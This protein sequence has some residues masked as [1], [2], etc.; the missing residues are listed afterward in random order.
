MLNVSGYKKLMQKDKDEFAKYYLG[1]SSFNENDVIIQ[2]IMEPSFYT[3][4]DFEYFQ[5]E[6][7]LLSFI[8][9]P[10][11][12]VPIR[13]EKK[14]NEILPVYE[15]FEGELYK[16]F[17]YTQKYTLKDFFTIAIQF[18]EIIEYIHDQDLMFL[19]LN[20][21]NFIVNIEKGQ[22]SLLGTFN[23]LYRGKSIITDQTNKLLS[24]WEI[25]YI[26]P[27]LTGRINI[28]ADYRANLYTLGI[29]FYELLTKK[30]PFEDSELSETIH[31]HLARIPTSPSE[32]NADIPEILSNIILKLLEKSPDERYQSVN[33]VKKDFEYCY[34]EFVKTGWVKKF[35]L[36]YQNKAT[37]QMK[38]VLF[39]REKELESL[40]EGLACVFGG[41]SKTALISG[42]SGSGKTGL[43]HYLHNNN[44]EN[45][46]LFLEGKFDQLLRN[47]PYAP[48]IQAFKTWVRII[49]SKGEKNVTIWKSK[50]LHELGPYVS[51]LSFLLPEIEWIIGKQ[52]AIERMSSYDNHSH[53][54]MMFQ[55][56]INFISIEC[57]LIIFIDDLQW[58]DA[59]S[60]ELICYLINNT[61]ENRLFLIIAYR[62]GID[63]EENNQVNTALKESILTNL[64]DKVVISLQPLSIAQITHWISIQFDIDSRISTQISS[65]IY[66][67]TAG[68][69]FFITQIFR[70]LTKEMLVSADDEAMEHIQL[71][72]LNEISI[73]EDIVSFI[74]SRIKKLPEHDQK[75]L[76]AASCLGRKVNGELISE[77]LKIDSQNINHLLQDAVTKGF[78]VPI[79]DNHSEEDN[80][81][82]LF[83]HDRVQQALYSL[84][85]LD[86]KQ[87]L[88]L[89]IGKYL[90]E[91]QPIHVN[92]EDLFEAVSH[93]NI[94]TKLLS[95]EERKELATLNARAGREAIKV[96]AFQAAYN[97]YY[98]AKG[99]L[100]EN[101]WQDNYSLTFEI[102]KGLGE[103]AYLNSNFKLAENTFKEVI[104]KAKTKEEKIK[105]YNNMIMLFTHLHRVNE[106]VDAGLKGLQLFNWNIKP[107]PR[108]ADIAKEL[109]LIQFALINKKPATL[110]NL[111]HMKE[112]SQKLFIETLINL[113]APSFHVN[114]NLSTYLMLKAF[115]FTL[116]NGQTDF[117]CLVFN[118]YSLIQSAGFNNF[119]DS[120]EYGN[121]ALQHVERGN[122]I[123]LKARVYF[124]FGTFVNHWRNPLRDNLSYLNEAQQLSVE[125]GNIHLAGASSS[126]II[127][128]MFIQGNSLK[129]VSMG[130]QKQLEFVKSINYRISVDFIH[131]MKHWLEVLSNRDVTP[132]FDMPITNSDQ[133]ADIIHYTLRLQMAFLLKEEEQAS[134]L[135][136]M[137]SKLITK[138]NVLVIT[139]EYYFYQ[140]LWLCRLY[141]KA[142]KLDRK[143]YIRTIKRNIQKMKKWAENAPVNY[144]HKYLLMKAEL[145]KVLNKSKEVITGYYEKAAFSAGES[146]FLQDEAI[147]YECMG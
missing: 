40:Y 86:E 130:V 110:L 59:A 19:H 51:A 118:N 97:F 141:E 103:S 133:S 53:Y 90:K 137:L 50:I 140:T 23:S 16:K 67:I 21:Y 93:L 138:T 100:Q 127:I 145:N 95:E 143:I 71:T 111:P 13:L 7:D 32:I 22:L 78:V 14:N 58:S 107:N 87:Y 46:F 81:K 101:S 34:D 9:H 48:I 135:L 57:P 74:I 139:P 68:N 79:V 121:I 124:V 96:A 77:I 60:L 147:I 3:Q 114:Q 73:N 142:T 128:T 56:L 28:Q 109:L 35:P 37:K 41:S 38:N 43:V 6:F 115:H 62:D 122:K 63:L 4:Y 66:K 11:I 98:E 2:K 42:P 108:K 12:V 24:S 105:L 45:N 27:E 25:A 134:N 132:N 75:L 65:I 31:S 125:S 102:M 8:H 146:G 18:C 131:E 30:L 112:P 120:Y 33:S 17:V 116:K 117:T 80:N 76:K 64:N 72:L 44:M 136:K 15:P 88:H 26:P 1:Y 61:R 123:N 119:S 20:P 39:G 113:N 106:A 70:S 54:L 91:N 49:L 84:L 89:K 55:K 82:F 129:E 85:S 5:R 69:P 94:C 52:P 36:N 83:I 126:F 29:I 144:Q 10:S 99:L 104:D 92:N 47:I